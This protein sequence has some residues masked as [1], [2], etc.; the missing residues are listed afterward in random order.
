[1]HFNANSKDKILNTSTFLLINS[2]LAFLMDAK[3]SLQKM[4]KGKLALLVLA[5]SSILLF[6]SIDI[7]VIFKLKFNI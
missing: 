6:I 1:M 4:H 3:S 2:P 7:H 5:L